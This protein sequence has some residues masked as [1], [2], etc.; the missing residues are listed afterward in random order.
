MDENIIYVMVAVYGVENESAAESAIENLTNG[1]QVF[2][3]TQ[4]KLVEPPE[5]FGDTPVIYFP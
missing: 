5:Q 4:T 2:A 3:V 1:E